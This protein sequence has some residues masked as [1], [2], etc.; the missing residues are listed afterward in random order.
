[1]HCYLSSLWTVY[2]P[3]QEPLAY[4]LTHYEY[5]KQTSQAFLLVFL[6]HEPHLCDVKK[7]FTK[8]A[9][10]HDCIL[11]LP[12]SCLLRSCG[13]VHIP[14]ANLTYKYVTTWGSEQIP[15]KEHQSWACNW[16]MNNHKTL[17]VIMV[18]VDL[19]VLR[20]GVNHVLVS[21]IFTV[22]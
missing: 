2:S 21:L 22:T 5:D 20:T 10:W 15:I 12:Y 19:R 6:C 14:I 11:T 18:K 13:D 17:D 8:C 3:H 7:P 9:P 16:R 4:Y 1:M